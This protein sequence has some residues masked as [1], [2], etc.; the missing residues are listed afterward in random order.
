MWAAAENNAAAVAALVELGADVNARS[1][2]IT[3][4][5]QRPADPS[6]Y[7]SSFVPKGQWTPLMYAARESALDAARTLVERGADVNVQDPDGVTPLLEPSSTST[8]TWPRCCSR[9]APIPRSPTTR[10]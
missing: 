1:A 5:A 7:V 10:A 6:N 9:R 2:T 8:T 3:Y 4:P